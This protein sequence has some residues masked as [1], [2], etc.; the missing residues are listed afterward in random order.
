MPCPLVQGVSSWQIRALDLGPAFCASSCGGNLSQRCAEVARTNQ[1]KVCTYVNTF[2]R[3]LRQR[4]RM[5][6][7]GAVKGF[8]RHEMNGRK[9]IPGPR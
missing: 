4:R 6:E 3:C 5:T 1:S 9:V 7:H 2:D 8:E